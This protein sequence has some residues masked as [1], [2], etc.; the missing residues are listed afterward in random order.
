M[1]QWVDN[2]TPDGVR[3]ERF[4]YTPAE[5]AAVLLD[6]LDHAIVEGDT[7]LFNS[8]G[9]GATEPTINAAGA[10]QSRGIRTAFW[11]HTPDHLTRNLAGV[12]INNFTSR[13]DFIIS[14]SRAVVDS[15]SRVTK[16]VYIPSFLLDRHIIP[17]DESV[18]TARSAAYLGRMARRKRPELLLELARCLPVD[19]HLYVQGARCYGADCFFDSFSSQAKSTPLTLLQES[20]MPHPRVASAKVFVNPSSMETCSLAILEAMN[21]GQIPVVTRFAENEDVV[22]DLGVLVPPTKGGQEFADAV[23][24]ALGEPATRQYALRQRVQDLFS[25]G[26]VAKELIANLACS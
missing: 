19:V 22:G 17:K 8:L 23:E 21:R 12:N 14:N 15:L 1:K 11:V 16:A 18:P 13:F 20:I 24:L 25:E 10:L 6:R 5:W 4:G 7:V 26:V 3:M 2:D 9:P